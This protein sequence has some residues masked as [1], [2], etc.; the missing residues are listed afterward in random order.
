MGV[1]TKEAQVCLAQKIFLGMLRRPSTRRSFEKNM[2]K[3]KIYQ[4]AA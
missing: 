2:I 1:K 3:A 4:E